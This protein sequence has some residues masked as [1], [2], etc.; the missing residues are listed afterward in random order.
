MRGKRCRRVERHISLR[1]YVLLAACC[2]LCLVTR[3]PAGEE[4]RPEPVRLAMDQGVRIKD[5]ADILG[6]R[7]NQL[8]GQGLLVGLDGSGDKS[9]T[10]AQQAL[11]NFVSRMGLNIPAATLTP[12]N[13]AVV[14]VTA[15]L[16]P[17][18][19]KGGKA[20]GAFP[21]RTPPIS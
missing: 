8:V 21:P 3:L 11:A 16:P 18:V 2:G 13:I 4:A 14:A 12:K 17:F 1:R 20:S 7:E 15:Q 6:V 10:L 5:I 9:S 19:K